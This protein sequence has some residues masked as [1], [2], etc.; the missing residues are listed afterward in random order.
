MEQTA[1]Y[2]WH[3]LIS[4]GVLKQ[5]LLILISSFFLLIVLF[6]TEPS[7]CFF[8]FSS[9]SSTEYYFLEEF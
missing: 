7:Y 1:D 3:N 6:C 2:F 4:M 9:F 5:E 8:L